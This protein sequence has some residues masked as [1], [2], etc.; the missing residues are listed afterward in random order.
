[1]IN[2]CGKVLKTI[3]PTPNSAI[4]RPDV[5]DNFVINSTHLKMLWE[6][7]FDDESTQAILDGTTGG[8]FL[9]KTPS[10]AFEYLEDKVLFELDWSTKSKNDHHQKSVAFAD[11]SNSNNDN[12][13]LMEKLGALTIKMVS[14]FQSLKEEMHEMRKNYNNHGGPGL[15]VCAGE[16]G[17]GATGVV[18]SGGMAG[19]VKRSVV[20]L[21]LPLATRT[22]LSVYLYSYGGF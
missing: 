5:D 15:G 4:I 19:E 18:G 9:Y 1:M 6:N 11:R 13:R 21:V 20:V 12:S 14:Q 10:Q 7:K 3:A 16:G 2:P 22:A 17:G 8:I